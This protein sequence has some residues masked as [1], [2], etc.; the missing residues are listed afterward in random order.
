MKP[1]WW[2]DRVVSD[3]RISAEARC[4]LVW[5]GTRPG[6]WRYS[7]AEAEAAIGLERKKYQ[8]VMKSVKEA[9]WVE[10][11]YKR[12]RF[13]RIK[14]VKLILRDTAS[15]EGA[16]STLRD[17]AT[18]RCQMKPSGPE[19]ANGTQTSKKSIGSRKEGFSLMVIGGR[20]A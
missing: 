17:R 1:L 13:G 10:T 12:D 14:Y 16:N 6:G 19:G 5:F 4:L 9:G 20:D 18:R 3:G 8:R 15:P 7:V 2:I 11:E